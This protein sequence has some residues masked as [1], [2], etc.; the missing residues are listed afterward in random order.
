MLSESAE[1]RGGLQRLMSGQTL[2]VGYL[3]GGE[4][5]DPGPVARKFKTLWPCPEP[6]LEKV[7]REEGI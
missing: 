3:L 6:I 1:I 7:I 4:D 5:R 2:G